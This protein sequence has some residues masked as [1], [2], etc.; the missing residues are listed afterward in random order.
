M[1]MTRE[2]E[3]EGIEWSNNKIGR[4]LHSINLI[5]TNYFKMYKEQ[6]Q[7]EADGVEITEDDDVAAITLECI[8]KRSPLVK[9]ANIQALV[10]AFATE[11]AE[12]AAQTAVLFKAMRLQ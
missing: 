6:K 3:S 8:E 11:A 12:S 7:K 9:E 1:K 2:L 5:C 4:L 10:N